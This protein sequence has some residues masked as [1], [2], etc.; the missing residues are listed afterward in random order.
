MR[1]NQIIVLDKTRLNKE[2]IWALQ[3]FSD[4]P[5]VTYEDCPQDEKETLHRIS[6]SDCVLVSWKTPLTAT[7]L[8]QSPNLRYIG[9]CCS[10]YDTSSS[11]VDVTTAAQLGIEVKAVRDY[12]DEGVVEFIFAQLI[13]Q[14][15]GL[16][17]KPQ[18]GL[19]TELSSKSIGIIGLGTLGKMVAQTAK[20][21][22][23]RLFYSGRT[24]KPEVE[25]LG[26]KR[27]SINTLFQTCDIIT[28]HVPRNTL[29]LDQTAFLSKKKK[30]VFINT[31]LGQPFEEN[32][33]LNWL[34]QDPESFAIFDSDGAG[35]LFDKLSKLDNAILY[36]LS[37]GFTEE[38]GKRLTEKTLQNIEAY[39]SEN[40]NKF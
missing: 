32:A 31:S 34:F 18:N 23:M 8:K 6:D 39:F 14:F 21:F 29:V 22:G 30:S 13:T 20:I 25:K 28:V 26:I 7:V 19:P 33:L 2:G 15:K 5:V 36:P 1:F 9:M 17:R 35:S 24:E 38:S 4:R 3:T 12:G 37:A 10:L 40:I 16:G 27:L 11:N